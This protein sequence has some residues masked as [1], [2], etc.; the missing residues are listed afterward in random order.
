MG[1]SA[2]G[3]VWLNAD[4]LPPSVGARVFVLH[5]IEELAR[6]VCVF[7]ETFFNQRPISGTI[8]GNFG[9]TPLMPT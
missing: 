6:H 8:T 3:A 2:S 9:E 4:R 1:K 5:R 7:A